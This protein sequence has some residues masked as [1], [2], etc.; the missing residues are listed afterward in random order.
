MAG[1]REE[2]KEQIDVRRPEQL[3]GDV[4]APRQVR[5]VRENENH[6]NGG[7]RERPRVEDVDA[8]AVLV[9]ADEFLREEANRNHHELQ[10]EQV[11]REAEKKIDTE[12]D[13]QQTER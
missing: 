7:Q 8:P 5:R 1:G 11:G 9:P 12:D 13:W 3:R 4:H 2:K 10:G 6:G